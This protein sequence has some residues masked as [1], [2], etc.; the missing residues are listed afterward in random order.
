MQVLEDVIAEAFS[1]MAAL[2]RLVDSLALLDLMVGLADV[3]VNGP[4]GQCSRPQL[5][6]GGPLA[7]VQVRHRRNRSNRTC[8]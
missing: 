7:I 3:A 2:Q 6:L 1:H 5:Q 4:M 8:A